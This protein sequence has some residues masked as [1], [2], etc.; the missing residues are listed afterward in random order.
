[1]TPVM[2]KVVL[3]L[4]LKSQFPDMPE[5]TLNSMIDTTQLGCLTSHIGD[6]FEIG[7]IIAVFTLCGLIAQEIKDNTLV[8]PLCSGKSFGG[9]VASK[10]LVFGLT[11]LL[12]PVISMTVDY[13][14]SGLLFSFDV[15]FIEIIRSGFLLGGYMVF[16]LV[17]LI[18]FGA[19]VKKP[20][21]AGILTLATGYGLSSLGSLLKID[22]YLPT[23]LISE[24]G[25]FNA[26]NSES[27][28]LTIGITAGIIIILIIITL[29]SLKKMEWNQR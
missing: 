7:S 25:K 4:A 17:C 22:K 16:L 20:V 15:D 29:V 11:L 5:E 6:I 1:M 18:M 13:I 10:L 9:I 27:L 12:T 3:P 28:I 26:I 24:A 23:G 14:Y 2:T 19:I 8:L 21:A